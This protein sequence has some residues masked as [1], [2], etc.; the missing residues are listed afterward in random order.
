MQSRSPPQTSTRT[1]SSK[2]DHGRLLPSSKAGRCFRGFGRSCRA[3]RWWH[4]RP[5]PAQLAGGPRS[6][7]RPTRSRAAPASRRRNAPTPPPRHSGCT[8]QVCPLAPK[9]C[10]L[11]P[12]QPMRGK[13]HRSPETG[14]SAWPPPSPCRT[15]GPR[16]WQVASGQTA[17]SPPGFLA[18]ARTPNRRRLMS[19]AAAG[20][21][22]MAVQR[23]S[24]APRPYQPHFWTTVSPMTQSTFG[25]W[26]SHQRSNSSGASAP[27][28][29]RRCPGGAAGGRRQRLPAPPTPRSRATRRLGGSG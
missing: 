19:V 21:L 4:D 25:H 10:T 29:R 28:R 23:P 16:S 15:G 13:T 22:A 27:R 14:L 24:S 18:P 8:P 17:A 6:V 20:K 11:P 7:G 2:S 1:P 12:R 3:T 26:S 5:S 9:P